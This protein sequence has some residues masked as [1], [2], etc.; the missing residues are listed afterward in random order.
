MKL[1]KLFIIFMKLLSFFLMTNESRRWAKKIPQFFFLWW[2][3]FLFSSVFFSITKV[4]NIIW[5]L[6][7]DWW[8][9]LN[10]FD[11]KKIEG[12]NAIFDVKNLLKRS[13]Y[14]TFLRSLKIGKG[15][16]HLPKFYWALYRLSESDAI[17]V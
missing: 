11:S 15:N 2:K 9:K 10:F 7:K 14:E 5:I 6:N 8:W 16:F 17:V 13:C 1:K 4:E 3:F 12:K